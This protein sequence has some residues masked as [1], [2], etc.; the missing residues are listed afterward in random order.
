M[1]NN[2]FVIVALVVAMGVGVCVGMNLSQPVIG[3][4]V[5]QKKQEP[6]CPKYSVVFTE[7]TNLCVT[8]NQSQTVYYYTIDQDRE[9]GDPLHLR[10]TLDLRDVGKAT[11]N[12]K[13]VK[14]K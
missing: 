12:P 7:G 1:K 11:L 14:K 5:V 2:Y 4:K 10:G 13:L 9:P 3:G 6:C 8:D